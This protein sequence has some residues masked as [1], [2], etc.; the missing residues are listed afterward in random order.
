MNIVSLREC[1]REIKNKEIGFNTAVKNLFSENEETHTENEAQLSSRGKIPGFDLL[2]AT[3]DRAYVVATYV[4]TNIENASLLS[5]ST[6]NNIHEVTVKL[7]DI[8]IANIYKPPALTWPA[9]VLNLYEHPAIYVGDFNSHHEMW[10][11]RDNDI[12]EVYRKEY[13]P[14]WTEESERL[15]EEF[16]EDGRQEIADELLHSIDTARREKWTKT[17]ENLDFQKS[18]R[19]AWSLL[20]KLGS[21]NPP[22]RPINL[23]TPNQVASHIVSTS[24][25]PQNRTHTIKVKKDLNTLNSTCAGT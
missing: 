17:V 9:H 20:R 4:S 14:G 22:D 21:S 19:Q 11:Y 10:K 18:S 6:E 3:Y 2:G 13:I 25:A 15:Y 16:C 8:T 1:E 12:N 23:V 5:T 24:R 7:G